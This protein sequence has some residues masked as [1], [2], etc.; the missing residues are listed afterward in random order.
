MFMYQNQVKAAV[1]KIG[2]PTK[3]S[4]LLGVSNGAIH[5]WIKA[6]RIPNV[7]YARKVAELAGM[8][9]EDVRP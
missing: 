2:G 6:R 5:A 4:N 8:R 1:R 3:T 9:V 7:D